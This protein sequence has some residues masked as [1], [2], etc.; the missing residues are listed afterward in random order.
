MPAAGQG[1]GEFV[2]LA[3][4]AGDVVQVA[5]LRQPAEDELDGGGVP[6]RVGGVLAPPVPGLGQRLQHGQGGDARPAAFGHQ[7]R[8]GR[9]AG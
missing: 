5:E 3:E 4:E 7:R 9:A 8:Q 2:D 1:L 6:D